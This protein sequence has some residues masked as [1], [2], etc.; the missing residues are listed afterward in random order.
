MI[1][2][3]LGTA[4]LTVAL[5]IVPSIA[6]ADPYCSS[7]PNTCAGLGLG[8]RDCSELPRARGLC[9]VDLTQKGL[10]I[11]HELDRASDDNDRHDIR[12]RAVAAEHCPSGFS[13]SE[14]KCSQD[15][16]RRG[17]KDMRLPGGLGCVR[18]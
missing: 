3:L 10:K 7:C 2:V 13:P 8:H 14:R 1:K 17:C 5:A 9:C 12:D 4:F 16:R 18:R 15:E 11:A 6:S